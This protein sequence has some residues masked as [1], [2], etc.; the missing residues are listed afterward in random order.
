VGQ[1]LEYSVEVVV[2]LQ[3]MRQ[4]S[5]EN[6]LPIAHA[7]NDVFFFKTAVETLEDFKTQNEIFAKIRHM[8][9]PEMSPRTEL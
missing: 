1:L 3:P 8:L 6:L 7:S 5:V 4:L 2:L 9:L